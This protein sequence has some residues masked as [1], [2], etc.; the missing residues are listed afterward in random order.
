MGND[1]I[2][3]RRPL[4]EFHHEGLDGRLPW[5][6]GRGVFQPVDGRDVRVVERGEHLRLTLEPRETV[7]VGRERGREDLDRHLALQL[8]IRRPI[9]LPHSAHTNLGGDLIGSEAATGCQRHK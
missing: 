1:E 8:R 2:R 5:T 7:R 6:C 4:D 3:E 9:H